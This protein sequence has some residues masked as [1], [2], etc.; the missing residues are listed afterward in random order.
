MVKNA[1]KPGERREFV[2]VKE[3]AVSVPCR[4]LKGKKRGSVYFSSLTGACQPVGR[5]T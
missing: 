1:S 5:E 3:N 2:E 4:E